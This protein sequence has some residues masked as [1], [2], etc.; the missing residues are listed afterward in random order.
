MPDDLDSLMM[1]SLMA[2]VSASLLFTPQPA[3][4]QEF[5]IVLRLTFLRSVSVL[6]PCVEVSMHTKPCSSSTT[7]TETASQRMLSH[8]HQT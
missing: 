6:S 5:W 4:W 7:A 3:A 8:L 2:F 1:L